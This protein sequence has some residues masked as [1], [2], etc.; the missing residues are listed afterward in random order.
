MLMANH[1]I[2]FT[3]HQHEAMLCTLGF[4]VQICFVNYMVQISIQ[5]LL[6]EGRRS[7]CAG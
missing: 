3:L 5:L 7:F 4:S 1:L 2:A 6:V